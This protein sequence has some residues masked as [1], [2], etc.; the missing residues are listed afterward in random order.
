[1]SSRTYLN[2]SSKL[3]NELKLLDTERAV[4]RR[5]DLMLEFSRLKFE[6]YEDHS[7]IYENLMDVYPKF[8]EPVVSFQTIPRE[9][10]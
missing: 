7:K 4:V 5:L 6:P 1:M 8:L 9:Q 10:N 2:Y 3:L